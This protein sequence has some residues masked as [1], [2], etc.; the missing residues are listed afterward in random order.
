VLVRV[1]YVQVSMYVRMSLCLGE[2][3]SMCV[4][5]DG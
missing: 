4:S 2:G 3:V 5:A 1:A